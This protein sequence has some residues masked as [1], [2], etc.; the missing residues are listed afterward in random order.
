MT[1]DKPRPHALEKAKRK[2][3]K[4]ALADAENRKVLVRALGRCEVQIRHS[5]GMGALSCHRRAQPQSHHLIFG[6]GKKNFGP[7]ILAEHRLA[8]CELHHDQITQHVLVPVP[9]CDRERADSVKYE[10]R[11]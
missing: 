11:L 1:F 9:G 3:E 5:D 10:R 8:V 6:I 4:H 2:A 7:S